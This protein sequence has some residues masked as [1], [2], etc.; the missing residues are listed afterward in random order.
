[1][2]RTKIGRLV[3]TPSERAR[4]YFEDLAARVTKD[5]RLDVRTTY[6]EVFD[7]MVEYAKKGEAEWEARKVAGVK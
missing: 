3:F 6:R 1:M 2:K 4:T 5:R 7:V